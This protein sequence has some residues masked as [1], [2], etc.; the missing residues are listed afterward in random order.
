MITGKFI[1]DNYPYWVTRYGNAITIQEIISELIGGVPLNAKRKKGQEGTWICDY[2]LVTNQGIKTYTLEVDMVK[3]SFP[4][5]KSE[6]R[7]EDLAC[8]LR[9]ILSTIPHAVKQHA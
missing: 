5:E 2:L 3:L 6:D 4:D 1:F 8:E 9:N 7:F